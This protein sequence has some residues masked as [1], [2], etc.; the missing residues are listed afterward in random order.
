MKKL[1]SK[2]SL[3]L[4]SIFMCF[5][6]VISF[7]QSLNI[8]TAN[9]GGSSVQESETVF[10]A[11]ISITPTIYWGIDDEGVLTI[12]DTEGTQETKG[13]F[14]G[15]SEFTSST[16]PYISNAES[17]T[18]IVVAGN[19]VPANMAYWFANLTNVTT[20]DLAGLDTSL[21]TSWF[22]TFRGM[23]ALE[24]IDIAHLDLSQ[25][26][27]FQSTFYLN[28][29]LRR[30][31]TRD[32]S[33]N[34]APKGGK[35][36]L[37]SSM[38][39]ACAKL[40]EV[41]LSAFASTNVTSIDYM[42]YDTL[43]VK[44]VDLSNIQLSSSAT[45][46][47]F[48]NA[49]T[50]QSN[51]SC[52]EA[53]TFHKSLVRLLQSTTNPTFSVP[54]SYSPWFSEDGSKLIDSPSNLY[55]WANSY[56]S[57][58]PSV[59]SIKIINPYTKDVYYNL[60]NGVLTLSNQAI[61]ENKFNTKL[62]GGSESPFP[63]EIRSGTTSVRFTGSVSV[64]NMNRWFQNFT[65]LSSINFENLHTEYM[66]YCIYTFSYTGFETLDLTPLNVKNV[67]NANHMVF[68][69]ASLKNLNVSGMNFTK[70]TN[71]NYMIAN[72]TELEYINLADIA[73]PEVTNLTYTFAGNSKLQEIDLTGYT[74]PKAQYMNYMFYNCSSVKTILLPDLNCPNLESIVYAFSGL[75]K[76][77]CLDLSSFTFGKVDFS[78]PA[79][80]ISF[81]GQDSSTT[82]L[83]NLRDFRASKA[84]LDKM[85][86][87]SGLHLGY[88]NPK[89]Y[90]MWFYVNDYQKDLPF[91]QIDINLLQDQEKH[92]ISDFTEAGRYI[93]VI[94]PWVYW[95]FNNVT[96]ELVVSDSP[97]A[98]DING[99]VRGSSFITGSYHYMNG[100]TTSYLDKNIIKSFRVEGSI[101]PGRMFGGFKDHTA[102]VSVDLNGI[103]SIC[104]RN[105]SELFYGCTALKEV[106]INSLNLDYVTTLKSM[107]QNC[108]ALETLDLSGFTPKEV[109]TFENMFYGCTNIKSI[110]LDNFNTPKA[111]NMK[112]MFQSC[113]V[114][115]GLNL[116]A[117][118]T[119]KVTNF[120]FMFC[121]M[122]Y[123]QNYTYTDTI[124]DVSCL[125]VSSGTDFSYMFR[126]NR[127]ISEINLDGWDTSNGKNFTHMFSACG[128]TSL[129][130]RHFNVSGATALT[131][132][133]YS[134]PNLKK[135]DISTFIVST[136]TEITSM[137]AEYNSLQDLR[138][139]ASIAN[140][141]KANKFT[142]LGTQNPS[143]TN[144][145]YYITDNDIDLENIDV[146]SLTEITE[147]TKFSNAGRYVCVI[148]PI[149]YWG[150][151]NDGV[152]TLS[153]NERMDPIKGSFSGNENSFARWNTDEFR[154]LITSIR[155]EGPIIIGSMVQ[156]FSGLTSLET[157]DLTGLSTI[158]VKTMNSLFS[159]CT[160][161]RDVNVKSLNVKNTI[162]LSA[163]FY[164]C[165]S[166][167]SVDLSTWTP[168]SVTNLSNL[169]YN[170]SSLKFVNFGEFS[171]PNATTMAQMFFG[172]SSLTILDLSRFNS[173]KVTNFTKM[174]YNCSSLEE[175]NLNGFNTSS[176][177]TFLS[178]FEGCTALT[179]L[180]LSS[181]DTSNGTNLNYMI[182]GLT[183]LLV[184]D[185]SNFAFLSN[186]T[187]VGFNDGV[188]FVR[189]IKINNA[190]GDMIV[191]GGIVFS[192]PASTTAI[193]AWFYLPAGDEQENLSLADLNLDKIINN[194]DRI[195]SHTNFNREGRY[196]RF[197]TD[198]VYWAIIG[199]E[200]IFSDDASLI[201]GASLSG[202]FNGGYSYSESQNVN[203]WEDEKYQVVTSAR[204][205][206]NIVLGSGVNFFGG[207]KN[208]ET[209]DLTGM[210]LTFAESVYK[211]FVYCEKLKHI[212]WGEVGKTMKYVKNFGYMFY[213]L[214]EI[215]E[216]DVSSFDTNSA[217]NMY[218]MF[219]CMFKLK[220]L[221]FT[222]LETSNV[223]DMNNMF[224]QLRE[225]TSLDVSGLNTSKVTIFSGMF[226]NCKN[227][228][229]INVS[230]FDFSSAT[231][232]NLMF[233]NCYAL[234]KL[235]LSN[236]YA[237]N[238]IDYSSMFINCYALEQLN[239]SNIGAGSKVS[240][241][242][243]SFV[244][245]LT[246]CKAI[247]DL[248]I[249]DFLA[250]NTAFLN[251]NGTSNAP[252]SLNYWYHIP[253]E[254]ADLPIDQ[255]DFSKLTKLTNITSFTNSGRYVCPLTAVVYWA[256]T[257]GEL[258][259]SSTVLEGD[260]TGSFAGSYQS[261]NLLSPFADYADQI[262]SV[263]VN[264]NITISSLYAMF[265]N[266]TNLET[267]D[268]IG[269]DTVNVANMAYLFAGCTSLVSVNLT[270]IDTTS[271]VSMGYMFY[272]CRSLKSIDLTN[273]NTSNVTNMTALFYLC[274]ELESLDLSSFNT[275]KV[276][277]FG[278]MFASCSK[279]KQLTLGENFTG[280]KANITQYMF[281]LAGL[282]T[283]DL[284]NFETTSTLFNVQYMFADMTNLKSLNLSK[285][286]FNGV[287]SYNNVFVNLMKIKE[288]Y[289]SE[290]YVNQIKTSPKVIFS[291]AS[292]NYPWYYV[293]EGNEDKPL[294]EL[295]RI[296]SWIDF[297]NAGRYITPL[298]YWV[299]WAIIDGELVLSSTELTSDTHG[300]VFSGRAAT[301]SPWANYVNQITS[302][303]I[304]GEI[305]IG[306][307]A[308]WFSGLSNVTSIDLTGLDTKLV[309]TFNSTFAN[310]LSLTNLV[311][312]T[313]DVSKVTTF[314][315][316]FH[317]CSSLEILDISNWV[318]NEATTLEYMFMGC[319]KLK[320]VDFG[321]FG[322]EKVT[323]LYYIFKDC[324][325]LETIN[326]SGLNPVAVQ[327]LTGMFYNCSTL[328]TVDLS[329]FKNSP[330]NNI[331][332]MFYGCT[333]IEEVD[334][335]QINTEA[336]TNF[337]YTFYKCSSLV[338]INLSTF[339]ARALVNM[340]H[341]FYQC[342]SLESLDLSTFE[343]NRFTAG[344]AYCKNAFMAL[345]SLQEIR[346]SQSVITK[347]MPYST[348]LNTVITSSAPWYERDAII[349]AKKIT[350]PTRMEAN[351]WYK[352]PYTAKIYWFIENNDLTITS[353]KDLAEGKDI[354]GMFVGTEAFT[355]DTLPWKDYLATL[356]SVVVSGS[357]TP[358]TTAYWFQNCT[359]LKNVDLSGLITDTTTSVAYMFNGCSSLVYLDISS[360]NMS[361]IT[362]YRGFLNN[363]KVC[364]TIVINAQQAGNMVNYGYVVQVTMYCEGLG[365][366][367]TKAQEMTVAG[368]Y[369][370]GAKVTFTDGNGW[371]KVVASSYGDRIDITEIDFSS[372]PIPE[373]DL[374]NHILYIGLNKW[375][376]EDGTEVDFND[377][378][379]NIT[380]YATY[381]YIKFK[382]P[383]GELVY[384]KNEHNI[385]VENP[386]NYEYTLN[387]FYN[388]SEENGIFN[389]ADNAI[390]AGY[391]YA[392]LAVGTRFVDSAVYYVN[393]LT[394]TVSGIVAE[395]KIFDQNFTATLNT[396]NA[397]INGVLA[398]DLSTLLVSASG[399][400]TNINVGEAKVVKITEITTNSPNYVVNLQDSQKE[401]TASIFIKNIDGEVVLNGIVDKTYTGS[402]ISQNF[403]VTVDGKMLT[404]GTDY[405]IQY[406]DNINAGE[407]TIEIIGQG[408]YS[409]SYQ[410]TFNINKK[411]IS[412][413]DVS[414]V[415]APAVYNGE[416]ITNLTVTIT[417]GEITLGT[418]DY[419]FGSMLNNISA[420][421]ATV[422]INGAGT[423]YE[424]SKTVNFK[425]NQLS[426]ED[427]EIQFNGLNDRYMYDGSAIT[428]DFTLVVNGRELEKN[429]D[430]TSYAINNT[431]PGEATIRVNGK[432]NYSGVITTNFTIAA[433]DFEGCTISFEHDILDYNGTSQKQVPTIVDVE[434][435]IVDPANYEYTY[436]ADT[437]NAGIVIVTIT[438][439]LKYLYSTA[440]ATYTIAPLSIND[441]T[442]M[443]IVDQ[444]YNGM[445]QQPALTIIKDRKT[446]VAGSDYDIEF[447]D[448]VNVGTASV[449]VRGKGNYE[450]TLNSSFEII[451]AQISKVALQVNQVSFNGQ[452][453]LPSILNVMAGSLVLSS[454]EYE[455]TYLNEDL[456]AYIGDFINSAKIV[457]KVSPKLGSNNFSGEAEVIYT[458]NPA[459]INSIS[460]AVNQVLFNA[461]ERMPEVIR[462]TASNGYI[463][464]KENGDYQLFYY[465]QA[466][467]GSY[468]E[469]VSTTDFINAG[470]IKV[471][472]KPNSTNFVEFAFAIF[473]ITKLS[474]QDPDVTIKYYFVDV[475]GNEI[476]DD[477]N[478][479][480]YMTE[481][482]FMPGKKIA[483][484][485]TYKGN[486][487]SEENFSYELLTIEGNDDNTFTSV[488]RYKI[489][490]NGTISFNGSVERA[491]KIN[492]RPFTPEHIQIIQNV[493]EFVYN[494]LPIGYDFSTEEIIVYDISD[495]NNKIRLNL[496]EHFVLANGAVSVTYDD[497]TVVEINPK[498]GYIFNTNA[499]TAILVLKGMDGKYSDDVVVAQFTITQRNITDC[500]IEVI[501]DLVY[502]GVTLEPEINITIDVDGEVSYTLVNGKD[503]TVSYEN[504]IVCG[505]ATVTI[506]GINNF[507]GTTTTSF[508]IVAKD[509]ADQDITFLGL[510]T[511]IFNFKEQKPTLKVIYNLEGFD[512]VILEQDDL[513][514]LDFVVVYSTDDFTN[515]GTITVYVFGTNNY[516]GSRELTYTIEKLAISEVDLVDAIYSHEY[517]GLPY[518]LLSKIV[519]KYEYFVKN[520]DGFNE[521]VIGVATYGYI[522]YY[523]LELEDGTFSE[524]A[525][526]TTDV[527]F[528]NAGKIRI[529]VG[530][531]EDGPFTINSEIYVDFEITAFTLTEENVEDIDNL[532]F[533]G[534]QLTPEPIV[535]ANG[536]VL[537][538]DIDYT[539]S[540]ENNINAGTEAIIK[541]IGKGS[542]KGIV[543]KFF[544]ITPKD[545]NLATVTIIKNELIYNG[546]ILSLG[547]E[548]VALTIGE[549]TLEFGKDFEFGYQEEVERISVGNYKFTING[550]GN[551]AGSTI[552]YEFTI[553]PRDL[554][555]LD[556]GEFGPVRYTGKL[557][558]PEFE[559][560]DNFGNTTIKIGTDVTLS[561]GDA[562][563]NLN[564]AWARRNGE[565]VVEKRAIMIV[566]AGTSGNYTGM[567]VI[568]FAISPIDLAT[569]ER[570]I[571]EP[572]LG[573][574]VLLD[575]PIKIIPIIKFNNGEE[576][577]TL[578]QNT[579]RYNFANYD[580]A[581]TATVTIVSQ[582]LS[583]F[584][585]SKDVFYTILD[586]NDRPDLADAVIDNKFEDVEY[587]GTDKMPNFNQLQ[588]YMNGTLLVYGED[589][590]IEYSMVSDYFVN[591]GKK[592]INITAV[593][594]GKYKGSQKIYFN[595]L[596]VDDQVDIF[597]YYGSQDNKLTQWIYNQ[598]DVS[599][600]NYSVTTSSG[601]TPK[602][603][604]YRVEDDGTITIIEGIENA[605]GTYFIRAT[606][607]EN[608]NYRPIVYDHF[609]TITPIEITFDGVK[610]QDK[611]YD[612]SDEAVINLDNLTFVG[613]VNDDEVS[614]TAKLIFDN[615]NA[616]NNKV[617]YITNVEL[618][619]ANAKNYVLAQSGCQTQTE[620]NI[621]KRSLIVILNIPSETMVYIK[622]QEV[623]YDVEGFTQST[624]GI[625]KISFTDQDGNVTYTM[626]YQVG[627][628][629]IEIVF[630]NDV[631]A[632]N[633]SLD[634]NSVLS[635]RITIQPAPI[636][637]ANATP[638][639][640]QEYT[641][642]PITPSVII[643]YEGHVLE[644]GVDFDV[645]YS[646][647]VEVGTGTVTVTCK[648]N[649][650]GEFNMNFEIV[651]MDA[652]ISDLK[653]E[654]FVYGSQTIPEP[655]F[656]AP[657]YLNFIITYSVG[658]DIEGEYTSTIPTAVGTYFVKVT[659]DGYPDIF[660]ICSF[661]ILPKELTANI[662]TKDYVFGENVLAPIV[663][664]DG[665]VNNDTVDF[666]IRYVCEVLGYD[667]SALPTAVG[668]Y[669]V[670]VSI[671]NKNYTLEDTGTFTIYALVADIEL[672]VNDYMYGED[673]SEITV[674]IKSNGE[675]IELPNLNFEF[676]YCDRLDGEYRR[677][678]P[679][680]AGI[681]FVKVVADND[682][683]YTLNQTPASFEI[684]KRILTI[685][686]INAES[687]VFDGTLNANVTITKVDGILDGDD[688]IITASGRF[689]D[690]NVSRNKVVTAYDFVLL[691]QSADNYM[692]AESGNRIIATASI[693]LAQV[694]D[695]SIEGYIG[696]YDGKEHVAANGE[697]SCI[698]IGNMEAVFAYSLDSGDNKV[699]G[700]MPMLKNVG[701]YT[702]YY[703]IS[704]QNH[705][706]YFGEFT[707]TISKATITITANDKNVGEGKELPEL[708]YIIE[709]LAEGETLADAILNFTIT[710]GYT[711]SAAINDVFDIIVSG[712]A[713]SNYEVIFVNGTLTVIEANTL[714]ELE[715]GS[716]LDF[717]IVNDSNV[718]TKLED[719]ETYEGEDP[720]YL[721]NIKEQTTWA[722][723]LAMFKDNADI[724]AVNKSGVML[725][726]GSLVGNGTIISKGDDHIIVIL[727]GDL[728]GD[729]KVNMF[730]STILQTMLEEILE[731]AE[732]NVTLA[733]DINKDGKVNMF[734]STVLQTHL[735]EIVNIFEPKE[736]TNTINN[737][738]K[739]E[740]GNTY[741][742]SISGV[743]ATF[744]ASKYNE[745]LKNQEGKSKMEQINKVYYF[746][747]DKK[748]LV[749]K[750]KLL[751]GEED[752][753]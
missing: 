341:A 554:A 305:C 353:L 286:N 258:V 377:L 538:K 593:K 297:K 347:I 536:I 145:W 393:P 445:P 666:T 186:V 106:N 226:S 131:C 153:T 14:A 356:K 151:S 742:Q 55:T 545:I 745:Q 700:T 132:M 155:I 477:Y 48:F 90:N 15:T 108:S 450:G 250:R 515:P 412:T 684:T 484:E 76:L 243:N 574:N 325:S 478:N 533:N 239:I 680:A 563:T 603:E 244:N 730:D 422:T 395:D 264:G 624:A 32:A 329:A 673:M 741:T 438:G 261:P 462:V 191:K 566:N 669:T 479:R 457:V 323:S 183:S 337:N 88:C 449:V 651:K 665:I 2:V 748:Y 11:A 368:R 150:I 209:V 532:E 525:L 488:G 147:I 645:T 675:I 483:P 17:I 722:E 552:E 199:N 303:R 439:Q 543:N 502:K 118:D 240:L 185:I 481:D 749:E 408:N 360:I 194:N 451:H 600:V 123:D 589:Y 381:T 40:E 198:Y 708:T 251:L 586:P 60:S 93:N 739:V 167:E 175:I 718:L 394:I 703:K 568:Y 294:S 542:Y 507:F 518:D 486:L 710:C 638:I 715:D 548:N 265:R 148:T 232:L 103:N 367:I 111:T 327:N 99:T 537:K 247:K 274:S 124:L 636:T 171:T 465:R 726:A 679:T 248:V 46:S 324:S 298:D 80:Y 650:I 442:F 729:G 7:R 234:K 78:K 656:K 122:Y 453:Q 575:E 557:L 36:T 246:N 275:A 459:V 156:M 719:R 382:L 205:V 463:L 614:L 692:L 747:E 316:A 340:T 427:C 613:I 553:V 724:T 113:Y 592:E 521:K 693:T 571:I 640:V 491:Y 493:T 317:N 127:M 152:L 54:T 18:K 733:A 469:T 100:S 98:G 652:A 676:V 384:N 72:N 432:G 526:L 404:A 616:G 495:P 125:N 140:L 180:D 551:F 644:L 235:D 301:N 179:E 610:A 621:A 95:G 576:I 655:S 266:L 315:Y 505:M 126:N 241:S 217:T 166:L 97:V 372:L 681:Y 725:E 671:N 87:Y 312:N 39:R 355:S 555:T 52:L 541:V 64:S 612:G 110:R 310:C 470:K 705:E 511:V 698:T 344:D 531:T 376:Y 406:I 547:A 746:V 181:F 648:G 699:Y 685:S 119:S 678:I 444:V 448:N 628:Y 597:L 397:I 89:I 210:D 143:A 598:Y 332:S 431:R 573:P 716:Y 428:P 436:S 413:S 67:I 227:I 56:I 336:I 657:E 311:I 195:T 30:I 565:L 218:G 242:A 81:F 22:F 709:G 513:G 107:F 420:G 440:K 133:L 399:M 313:L 695:P 219:S 494:G 633:Y 415:I 560:I 309:T 743:Q 398:E 660:E 374:V 591:V 529:F 605:A 245:F 184:L 346:A 47:N 270:N 358:A 137:L 220:N 343:L 627:V 320:T 672:D 523:S 429:K 136:S 490:V 214:T 68:E 351:V 606:I 696:M 370:G 447:T 423:N 4:I 188:Y 208:L 161:L 416:A 158:C 290:S 602:I 421:T 28:S 142:S 750:K 558:T 544:V 29:N 594:G 92:S 550:I 249:S 223:T 411:D 293:A 283:L 91:N 508:K 333:S 577:I 314:A 590:N 128:Y 190:V 371:N 365:I 168:D 83:E 8:S 6:C 392:K 512:N 117:F 653:M 683:S 169:F 23:T 50:N 737:T 425:I 433:L 506:N 611:V 668:V 31:I 364:N 300:K 424:G 524:K 691:G 19:V 736:P 584:V 112:S 212:T 461:E 61:S 626:P 380:V 688:I 641:S 233:S 37:Y 164:N 694:S 728:N 73:T 196:V 663:T 202:R 154:S 26:T 443:E 734:D 530:A 65:N 342:I 71:T 690:I 285:I 1:L 238:V 596:G 583:N 121:A 492:P 662:E 27:T 570:I 581:G 57:S 753:E 712:E 49:A 173:S 516:T 216:L 622:V 334:L 79:N 744:E 674:T 639:E 619:G 556:F 711:T 632:S 480:I 66:V 200:M 721:I 363:L 45:A 41:D 338:S 263:R 634:T 287:T 322:A 225:V 588:V 308:Y 475:D 366:D 20:V 720:V 625:L 414:V 172:C 215:E 629:D 38:L 182:K 464:D 527:E 262:R 706:D 84:V 396:D 410:T 704:A 62:V 295:P 407:A 460:I 86:A 723:L 237:P 466:A 288:I 522:L 487:V 468:D 272:N 279:L 585:G 174:F 717:A 5:G 670:F 608:G 659:I 204:I 617:V 500:N 129:D 304:E 539:L 159:G 197:L 446:L 426:L 349:N 579:F 348:G 496:N 319:L 501:E 331:A 751:E 504:N 620:A 221:N 386:F 528:I 403:T 178:M 289:L 713:T 222:G 687:K 498:N 546:T 44:A 277:N 94:T 192:G 75:S 514:G 9:S 269:L 271:L 165:T 115:E 162:Y 682:G 77:E 727:L 193:G 601:R 400:F 456:T 467:D 441:A 714:I 201:E 534:Q 253:S 260:I 419:S 130:L 357:V 519:V 540:Y 74:A 134:M 280:I 139:S 635:G 437:T 559:L 34:S 385:T 259:L 383:E 677:D 609:F 318:G 302:I 228:T 373:T 735:E 101:T 213:Y 255:I 328:K 474:I 231:A 637:I 85:A 102:L 654:D 649:F 105:L 430:Y 646:N 350:A 362:N 375:V 434:G 281:N 510:D 203:R 471:V 489:V 401:A 732:K 520:E 485:L 141:F 572:I 697:P 482:Q 569:D 307:M 499:G 146:S 160:A 389:P 689:S 42:F 658:D 667:S 24:E 618:I 701:T 82:Y 647:N 630:D 454:E 114:L 455:I 207:L 187:L 379:G 104:I 273:F 282:E 664:L 686:M 631:A 359:K 189:D 339:A 615:A 120:S 604:F 623:D 352:N 452:A 473:E 599:L 58:N 321:Q 369:L 476:L 224:A 10:N 740:T 267:A 163:I 149:V 330:I 561:Y 582:T 257:H 472:A 497:G 707:V 116:S 292:A 562:S 642:K 409:G 661:R 96:G 564:V 138:L 236:F 587:D 738:Q 70:L 731:D 299:Y 326:L 176:A 378:T 63:A 254:Q 230:N 387:Y 517:S 135:L 268:L 417:Y 361:S 12:S 206:G 390:N 402:E 391:Y 291:Y 567:A 702:V 509:I 595:I 25:V 252:S 643:I 405:I 306:Y 535:T 177:T 284:S 35:A 51:E 53:F 296:T 388:P 354:G 144:P 752:E 59:T 170:C 435:N 157:A 33:G 43:N 458:I 278:Y 276:G 256:I 211:M 578:N 229:E 3:I 418:S 345:N 503:F 13:N 109:T 16:I 21:C 69:N 335:T 607:Q 580:K 549:S